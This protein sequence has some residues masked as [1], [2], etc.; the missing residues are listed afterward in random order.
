MGGVRQELAAGVEV[1]RITAA[2]R[3]VLGA[4]EKEG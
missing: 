4:I 3:R 2:G 1:A